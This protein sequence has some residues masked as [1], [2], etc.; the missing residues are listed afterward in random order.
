MVMDYSLPTVTMRQVLLRKLK[1]DDAANVFKLFSDPES[2]QFD[3]GLAMTRLEDAYQFIQVFSFYHPQAHALR[4]A[5]IS[6]K[7][8]AFMGTGGFHKIDSAHKRAELGGEL[9]KEYRQ[10]GIAKEVMY[11]LIDY[12]FNHIGF[13]RITAMVSPDNRPAQLLMERGP[14]KK[15]G[16]LREWENWG[17]HWVDLNVYGLLRRDWQTASH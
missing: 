6:R 2:M 4:W 15:E 3:G 14:F 12:G 17:G 7:T 9:L 16:C 8:G 11:G 10:K 1:M 5:V 13:N